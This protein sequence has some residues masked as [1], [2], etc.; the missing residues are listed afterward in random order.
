MNRTV[1]ITG[2]ANGIGRCLTEHF[3]SA[4]DAV[5]FLDKEAKGTVS[6]TNT[7]REKGWDVTG[8]VGDIADKQVLIDFAEQVLKA[9]PEGIHC[10]INNACLMNGGILSDCDYEDF[11]YVQRV[12]VAAPFMLTKLF[13][14]HFVGI[15]SVV[16]ISSTRCFQSQ[17]NTE[18][19]TAA[20]GGITAL[21]HALAIS[22]GGI[23]RVNSIAPGWID[24]GAYHDATYK[25]E[26]SEGDVMQHPS[27]RIGEPGDIARAVAFLCD[28][29][30]S[31]V[32]GT[33]IVVD[34]GI[35]KLMVYH[36]DY[37]WTY[38]GR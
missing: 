11:L 37:G 33:N 18:S 34:G 31:F 4:G 1:V 12:G 28:E 6:T 7:M 2:G 20:K 30:N 22:L 26:Y 38:E 5:Y 25:P 21:T 9:H 16:N 13:K 36:N 32:N 23:A 19:Y 24:T 14:D 15:G 8:I 27:R 35:S 3:A 10:L 17:A 29:K